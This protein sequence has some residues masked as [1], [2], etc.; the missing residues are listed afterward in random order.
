MLH[1]DRRV[2][3]LAAVCFL[4]FLIAGT[5]VAGCAPS[6]DDDATDTE[7]EIGEGH[8]G[9]APES[10][11]QRFATAFAGPIEEAHGAE[12]WH[13]AEAVTA[14]AALD[15]AG[16]R[17]FEATMT[18]TPNMERVRIDRADDARIY[19]ADGTARVSP[20]DAEY[21]RARFHV[22]TW[23]YFL[24]A[25][26]KLRDPGTH[27]ESLGPREMDGTSYDTAR[28]T[29]DSGVGDSPDDWYVVYRDAETQ[30]VGAM[31]YIVTFGT[32]TEEAEAEPHAIRYTDYRDI[33]GVAIPHTWL[34][35][36]WGEEEGIHGEPIGRMT[37]S[38]V[39]L[40]SVEAGFFTPPEDSREEGMPPT[41]SANEAPA[42]DEPSE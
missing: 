12:A 21:P 27:L 19:W 3:R 40:E 39:G 30:R 9:E 28:L 2:A 1:F 8:A 41:P 23:P 6:V 31:A 38:E 13:R 14:E 20:A 36:N 26:M 42:E 35:Y 16:N 15:F 33:A 5:F 34:F 25:P 4:S 37:L 22:L 24:A 29:F 10:A 18:F 17:V 7:V 32:A 11:D